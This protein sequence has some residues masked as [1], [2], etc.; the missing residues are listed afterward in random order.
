MNSRESRVVKRLI[1]MR[2][3]KSSWKTDAPT[4]HAR[5]LNRRGKNDAPRV[6]SRLNEIGWIPDLVLSSDAQRTRETWELMRGVF[7]GEIDVEFLSHLY[8]GGAEALMAALSG[9]DQEFATVL[10]LGHNPGWQEVVTE[11]TGDSIEMTTANAALL[12]RDGD[13][14]RDVF[15]GRSWRLHGVIRPRE[16]Q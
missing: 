3:A 4:D 7:D 1:I 9:V 13:S 6:A 11:L 10:A 5:P 15:H 16:L 2:H 12:E 8:H 14:W